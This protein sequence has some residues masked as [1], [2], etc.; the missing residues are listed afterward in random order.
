MEQNFR[1]QWEFHPWGNLSS[2]VIFSRKKI[3]F[4]FANL[5]KI[6]HYFCAL[7]RFS[8]RALGNFLQRTARGTPIAL[9]AESKEI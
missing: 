5:Q 7:N 4:S 8:V 6:R 9:G 2:A 3:G 1:R